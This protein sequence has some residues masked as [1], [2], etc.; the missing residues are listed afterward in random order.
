MWGRGLLPS[1]P[2]WVAAPG[3]P[4]HDPGCWAREK[5]FPPSLL[6]CCCL[7]EGI[8]ED[9][10][11]PWSLDAPVFMEGGGGGGAKMNS[12]QAHRLCVA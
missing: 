1:C 11:V 2:S 7:A 3:W 6:S 8:R 12:A 4:L 9:L 5:D 10:G